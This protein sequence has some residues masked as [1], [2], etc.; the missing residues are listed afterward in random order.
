M[1][2]AHGTG[3]PKA[4]PR[5]AQYRRWRRQGSTGAKNNPASPSVFAGPNQVGAIFVKEG[6][7]EHKR[8]P[9]YLYCEYCSLF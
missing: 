9:K 3:G 8:Y 4:K 5:P 2:A 1:R 7:S 6:G